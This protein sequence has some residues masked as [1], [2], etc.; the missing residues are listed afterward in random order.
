MKLD[1]GD[2][3]CLFARD[4]TGQRTDAGCQC[5]PPGNVK[6]RLKIIEMVNA[7]REISKKCDD[8]ECATCCNSYITTEE[9]NLMSIAKSALR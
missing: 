8:Y 5:I 4:K 7:L 1:C 2:H 9:C 6:L 3:G